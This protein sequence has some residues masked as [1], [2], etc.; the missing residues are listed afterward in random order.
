MAGANGASLED[1][2]GVSREGVPPPSS[3]NA[4][5]S[6]DVRPAPQTPIYVAVYVGLAV[7]LLL[8]LFVSWFRADVE[9]ERR[10]VLNLNVTFPRTVAETGAL[11][12]SDGWTVIGLIL[13]LMATA[14]TATAVLGIGGTTPSALPK[15]DTVIGVVDTFILIAAFLSVVPLSGFYFG[16][17]QGSFT[18]VIQGVSA[19]LLLW[20]ANVLS[21]ASRTLAESDLRLLHDDEEFTR[22]RLSTDQENLRRVNAALERRGG[23]DG[24]LVG[25]V[26]GAVSSSLVFILITA[27]LIGVVAAV[28]PNLAPNWQAWT[29]RMWEAELRV[30]VAA[31]ILIVFAAIALFPARLT[32]W[33]GVRVRPGQ[34]YAN[35]AGAFKVEL[36]AQIGLP[37][38]LLVML[39]VELQSL[40]MAAPELSRSVAL[41]VVV[42]AVMTASILYRGRAS[43]ETLAMRVAARDVGRQVQYEAHHLATLQV[44]EAGEGGEAGGSA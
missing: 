28:V 6:V 38:L 29:A 21:K 37:L 17:T 23:Q 31:A 41:Y 3:G 40:F 22:A 34:T 14:L 2:A 10:G 26:V 42:I 19:L 15:R 30:L 9:S 4:D 1:A 39:I 5:T 43:W 20:G 13:A 27:A 24:S 25:A 33:R 12:A 18:G 7:Y 36:A 16:V 8:I 11:V 32:Y 44:V 35:A